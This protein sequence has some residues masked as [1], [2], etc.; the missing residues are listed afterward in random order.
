M[1]NPAAYWAVAAVTA[2]SSYE[3]GQQQKKTNRY[4][5]RVLENE[6]IRTRNKGTIEEN[7]HREKVQQLIAKQR[8]TTAA[9]GVD[10]NSGSPL[11]LQEDAALLGEV[12][13]LTIRQNYQDQA[14]AKDNRGDLLNIQGDNA[15]RSGTIGAISTLGS[16][17]FGNADAGV[18]SVWYKQD[19]AA[20]QTTT[21]P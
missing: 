15:V 7:K 13:A 18:S 19:S 3:Q 16:A 20:N 9:S 4:N 12:D 1:C 10:V 8:A 14:V 2:Y 17:S 21:T 5:A 11:Q 6:A